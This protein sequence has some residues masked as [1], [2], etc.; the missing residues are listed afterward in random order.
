MKQ[1]QGRAWKDNA[2]KEYVQDIHS[3]LVQLNYIHL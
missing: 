2:Y 1:Q 3:D